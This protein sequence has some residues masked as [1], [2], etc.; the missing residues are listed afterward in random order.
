VERKTEKMRS[1]KKLKDDKEDEER[2][3]QN[4]KA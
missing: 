1:T 2:S 4:F 3:E